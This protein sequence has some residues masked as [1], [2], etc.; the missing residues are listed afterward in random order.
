MKMDKT[1]DDKDEDEDEDEDRIP[2]GCWATIA[3]SDV[4]SALRWTSDVLSNGW[5]VAWPVNGKYNKLY[6]NLCFCVLTARD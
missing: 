2:V 4:T 3:C 1:M 5:F 6:T